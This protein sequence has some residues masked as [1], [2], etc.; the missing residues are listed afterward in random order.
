[1]PDWRGDGAGSPMSPAEVADVVAW[2][3]DK[4]A[5]GIDG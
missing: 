2:L 4:R 5:G 3:I 1:M